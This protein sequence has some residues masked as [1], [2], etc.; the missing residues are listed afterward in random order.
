MDRAKFFAALRRRGS[1]VFGTSLS[2]QQVEGVEAIL[3]EGETR[4][5]S[6]FHLAAILAEVYHE[7]GGTMQPVEENLNY[8]AKRLTQVWPGRFP[9]I[10]SAQP[11][12]NNPQKLANKVYGGRMGNTGPNDGWM[13][14]G[15]G[16]PQITGRDN[17]RRA[18]I[19]GNPDKALEMVTA[20]RILFDGMIKGTFTGKR[21]VDYDLVVTKTPLVMSFRYYASRAIINGDT[22]ANGG[23]IDTYGKAFEA[24]LKAADYTGAKVVPEPTQTPVAVPDPVKPAKIEQGPSSDGNWL[25]A[26]LAAIIAIFNRSRT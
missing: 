22:A 12:A 23:H 21:L 26:L 25:S 1:G 7:T 17:Y 2:Q 4:G 20:V 5:V 3:D 11:Y 6:A 24:A 14:R 15:R 16:L 8:S 13:F 10:A 19:E 18:G 9:T